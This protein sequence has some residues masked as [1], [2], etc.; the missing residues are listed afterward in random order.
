MVLCQTTRGGRCGSQ[1]F[2]IHCKQ[3]GS[4]QNCTEDRHYCADNACSG[5]RAIL[6]AGSAKMSTTAAPTTTNVPK[7]FSNSFLSPVVRIT[8]APPLSSSTISLASLSHESAEQTYYLHSAL[9]SQHSTYFTSLL[10]FTS[11]SQT[12][13]NVTL[14]E[15]VDDPA[16]FARF[17]EFLYCADYSIPETPVTVHHGHSI[18]GGSTLDLASVVGALTVHAKCYALGE[19]LMAPGF[20]SLA[21]AKLKAGLKALALFA[22]N[23]ANSSMAHTWIPAVVET[24]RIIYEG[25]H[26]PYSS[27]QENYEWAERVERK[28]E[29]LGVVQMPPAKPYSYGSRH[30]EKGNEIVRALI[31]SNDPARQVLANFCAVKVEVLK[32]REEFRYMLKEWGEFAEDLVLEV[33]GPGGMRN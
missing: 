13:P 19:R 23:T 24:I 25:T 33:M 16:A 9:L 31:E 20:K 14:S 17:V 27:Q 26:R 1:S 28:A 30:K 12:S 15:P 7:A 21:L 22:P 6:L 2:A 5:C 10:S 3:C 8:L 32:T 11:N 4:N 29:E 18:G